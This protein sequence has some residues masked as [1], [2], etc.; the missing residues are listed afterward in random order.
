VVFT[1]WLST[2]KVSGAG[3]RQ[4]SAALQ[5]K[6]AFTSMVKPDAGAKLQVSSDAIS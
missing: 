3:Q 2:C 4:R 5:G 6:I 1:V